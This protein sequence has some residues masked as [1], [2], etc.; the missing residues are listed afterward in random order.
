M[1][2]YTTISKETTEF[3]DDIPNMLKPI[4]IKYAKVIENISKEEADLIAYNIYLELSGEIALC[5]LQETVRKYKE[6]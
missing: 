4:K 2:T 1:N 3:I 6:K 5:Y